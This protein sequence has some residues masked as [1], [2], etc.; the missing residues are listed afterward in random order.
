MSPQSLVCCLSR[1]VE[2]LDYISTYCRGLWDAI[3]LQ[4]GLCWWR[5]WIGT[6]LCVQF[7]LVIFVR[8]LA[9]WAKSPNFSPMQ[10]KTTLCLTK[11]FA[12]SPPLSML[13]NNFL[14]TVISTFRTKINAVFVQNSASCTSKLQLAQESFLRCWRLHPFAAQDLIV[15]SQLYNNLVCK[16]LREKEN[17]FPN[18]MISSFRLERLEWVERLVTKQTDTHTHT[19]THDITWYFD[20]KCWCQ[21]EIWMRGQVA[22]QT[23]SLQ[24]FALRSRTVAVFHEA[25][26]SLHGCLQQREGLLTA[27]GH[28]E[29]HLMNM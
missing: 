16:C 19:H 2:R 29:G 14:S 12:S 10:G 27:W 23:S 15:T 20:M 1:Y 3:F 28:K 22:S 17:T 11:M 7:V 4:A 5:R 25:T 24:S 18:L 13:F 8:P 21:A 9:N 26:L 6:L